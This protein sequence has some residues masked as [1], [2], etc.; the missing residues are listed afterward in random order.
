MIHFDGP[1]VSECPK[2]DFLTFCDF[3]PEVQPGVQLEVSGLS[4]Q[5]SGLRSQVSGRRYIYIYIYIY[6]YTYIYNINI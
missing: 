1:N 2:Y 5:V 6:I 4:S 3:V